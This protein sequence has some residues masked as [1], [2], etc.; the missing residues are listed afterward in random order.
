MRVRMREC[1]RGRG[2]VCGHVCACAGARAC[3]FAFV[4]VRV[5]VRARAR[6]RVRVHITWLGE[7]SSP[8]S[9]YRK[10]LCMTL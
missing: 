7:V 10:P 4:C 3:A 6:V 9:M 8:P 2:H 1:A 5:R